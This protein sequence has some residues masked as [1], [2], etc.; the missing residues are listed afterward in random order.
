MIFFIF[1]I[2][3]L[4]IG[5]IIEYS[6]FH[7]FDSTTIITGLLGGLMGGIVGLLS[8]LFISAYTTNSCETEIIETE[9]VEIYALADN[10]RYSSVMTGVFIVQ[11][12]TDEELKYGYMY[13]IEGKGYGFAEVSAE[14]SYLNYTN[15]QPKIIIN[16]YDYS[17]KILRK[18]GISLMSNKKEYIFYIPEDSQVIDNYIID[19]N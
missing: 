18:L 10:P 17:S 7:D 14:H 3:G 16:T 12:I 2:I 13:K 11:S 5:I 4:I 8:I 19:F 1:I 6:T 9:E 15:E